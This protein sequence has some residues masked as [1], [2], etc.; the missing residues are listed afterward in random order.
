MDPTFWTESVK[1][2]NPLALQPEGG[3]VL[4][5]LSYTKMG[6]GYWPAPF[7][8]DVDT[9]KWLERRH[10]TQICNRWATEHITDLQQA[11]FNGDGFVSW[12]SVWGTWNGLS[13]RDAEATRRVGALLRFLGTPFFTSEDWEPHTVL[14]SESA[15]S[16]LFASLWPA[17]A[18][19]GVPYAAA[20][21][22]AW[23]L[24]NRG[25]ASITTPSILVPCA[26]GVHYYDLYHGMAL[27]L[28]HLQDGGCALTF[29]VEALG[30]GA[31]LGLAASDV[32]DGT[33][34][35]AVAAF[36]S[37]MAAMTAAPLASLSPNATLR[38][39]VQTPP[40]CNA[41]PPAAPSGSVLIEGARAWPFTVGG[42][43]LRAA[44]CRAMTSSTRR[45][46]WPSQYT[47]RTMSTCLA[48]TL[49]QRP[50]PTL[51]TLPS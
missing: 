4:E 1:A 29:P 8:P 42:Q 12:E 44:R 24:V 38:Q 48:C 32:P 39:Q 5:S 51:P 27:P 47:P 41:R 30:F 10:I 17:A 31:V 23:T 36:L 25:T 49:T 45:S 21:A 37:T 35:A 46:R 3:P 16:G 14:V 13:V 22:S 6:W 50:S 19:A 2:G 7:I 33:P 43:R 26:G 20:N 40:S 28:T 15:A 18:G 34:P 11:L 9:W